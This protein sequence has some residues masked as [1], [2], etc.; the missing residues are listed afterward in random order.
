MPTVISTLRSASA[1]PLN[2]YIGI[3]S[4]GIV[5]VVTLSR[6]FYCNPVT[7]DKT[8]V[9]DCISSSYI[10]KWVKKYPIDGKPMKLTD[11]VGDS[12]K[13]MTPYRE[14]FMRLWTSSGGK[15]SGA[16]LRWM[17]PWWV[18]THLIQLPRK[19]VQFMPAFVVAHL[20]KFLGD[21]TAPISV[22]YKLM[23][24]SAL[25]AICEKTSELSSH[26]A[27]NSGGVQPAFLGAQAA[28]YKKMQTMSPRGRVTVSAAEIQ[29]VFS[30][31][32]G[33]KWEWF[34]GTM[35]LGL[36]V[37][38]LPAGYF[39]IYRLF[40]LAAVLVSIGVNFG[41]TAATAKVMALTEAADKQL[42]ELRK[43]QE[44]SLTELSDAL[45][46]WK[47]YGWTNMFIGRLDTL[48]E[49]LQV[50]GR[51]HA[52][53]KATSE[54]LPMTIGPAA[55]LISVGIDVVSGSK[56]ELVKLLT[57]GQFIQIISS[58][59][60]SLQE[61][62]AKW[63]EFKTESKNIDNI[64]AL[65]DAEPL[66]RSTD[67]SITLTR[68]SFG[69][70][71]KPV[72]TYEVET[73][74]TEC[75]TDSG[76]TT[77]LA[78]GTI[79]RGVEDQTKGKAVRVETADGES[80]G[81]VAISALKKLPLPKHADWTPPSPA[82]ADVNLMI[83]KGELVLVSGPVAGGTSSLLQ[84]L[85]GNTEMLSGKLAVPAS[86]AF[87]P[88]TPILFDQ[89]IRANILFGIADDNANEDFIQQSLDASTLSMDM[90][91]SESTLHAKRE[92]TSA[93]QNGSELS[94]GQ[95]ARVALARCFY[96]SLAGS[97]C[98]ILDDPI[99]A[100]DPATAARCWEK[101]IKGTL[102]GKTRVVVVNSQMLQRFATDKAVSRLIFV[103]DGRIVY[104][105]RPDGI[106]S[107]VAQNL[108]DG[109]QIDFSD[110]AI[111]KAK[112]EAE[113]AA[114]APE[115]EEKPTE[116]MLKAAE[117]VTKKMQTVKTWPGPY[118]DW[119]K[120]SLQKGNDGIKEIIGGVSKDMPEIQNLDDT[121][122]M[123]VMVLLI[124]GPA[125]GRPFA[126]LANEQF[127]EINGPTPEMVTAAEAIKKKMLTVKSWPDPYQQWF[128]GMLAKGSDGI[129]E[130]I[131]GVS[132]DM[133]EFA[134]A[135]DDFKM[136]AM[137]VLLKGDFSDLANEQFPEINGV[138]E[139]TAKK[140][141][142]GETAK[143]EREEEEEEPK[144]DYPHTVPS[145]IW[146]YCKRQGGFV[147]VSCGG[148]FVGAGM[149]LLLYGWN[150]RWAANTLGVTWSGAGRLTHLKNYAVAIGL[151]VAS[152]AT[153]FTFK[154]A[155]GFGL[156]KASKT[157]RNDVNK[158]L[159]V[160]AMPYLWDPKNST[161]QLSDLVTRN[162]EEFQCFAWIPM[163]ISAAL[164]SLGAVVWSQPL[165]TPVAA[166]ALYLQKYVKAPFGWAIRQVYGGLYFESNIKIR[167]LSREVFES[168]STIRAMGR[169]VDCPRVDFIYL[170]FIH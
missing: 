67:G 21:P 116:E 163:I 96:A 100:L 8:T 167:K 87:Q 160:L 141:E 36:E 140:D 1:D 85:V 154:T 117:A 27:P 81:Y 24:L 74:G 152:Q 123:K 102:A 41:I 110:E 119:F 37:A 59:M 17:A 95:Q 118:Q 156:E 147:L 101:G 22:G 29:T 111:A 137:Q 112:A 51:W 57:A 9:W 19:M 84:S 88:Q 148:S 86:I 64:L 76:V 38:S 80:D 28:I 3:T 15:T 144:K 125:G 114:R 106:P 129:K 72:H 145:S 146:D 122:K 133:P 143:K 104:N 10:V 14:K 50:A 20:V 25:R 109:Y 42:R 139:P 39:F 73:N 121:V 170:I 105:G 60:S 26:L 2:R 75:E 135:D 78:K 56:I 93:G 71:I 30:K 62:L 58:S 151:A 108:G 70:P 63:R 162:P 91:D 103:A 48:T 107:T 149:A 6:A 150:E 13:M 124:R 61:A 128:K 126:D 79:V 68:A 45:P 159:R 34:G 89:T 12:R 132:K 99:K 157:I 130:I 47:L 33:G 92:M 166:V 5:L 40:G 11:L 32:D 138:A 18:F 49:E 54:V 136:K 134:E 23:L 82:V 35:N 153:T 7:E 52:I 90:D 31:L 16:L 83:A 142:G 55:V 94:G 155:Y 4:A 98:V 65:P 169:S 168:S 53:W 44:D 113:A 77:T 165:L 69:W 97:E 164:L 131:K 115:P 43:R 127:P 46:I 66:E 120:G 161:A 158:K